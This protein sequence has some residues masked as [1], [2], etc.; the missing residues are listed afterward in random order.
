MEIKS[1]NSNW[2]DRFDD[3][4][5]W[6]ND[7]WLR[8]GGESE[9]MEI[10]VSDENKADIATMIYSDNSKDNS[11]DYS[12]DDSDHKSCVYVRNFFRSIASKI[13][14]M[15]TF[16]LRLRDINERLLSLEPLKWWQF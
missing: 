15:Q 1:E 8:D 13:S 11:K 6:L 5:G 16:T 9:K 7:F 2:V 4:L 3:D 12:K 14:L 10:K